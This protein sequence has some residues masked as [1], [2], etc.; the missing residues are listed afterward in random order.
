MNRAVSWKSFWS[1]LKQIRIYKLEPEGALPLNPLS[2]AYVSFLRCSVWITRLGVWGGGTN[3]TFVCLVLPLIS[4][5]IKFLHVPR[6]QV[7]MFP[8]CNV[9]EQ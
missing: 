7:G 8:I 6:Q 9:A 2:V 3:G 1:N 5:L 4:I